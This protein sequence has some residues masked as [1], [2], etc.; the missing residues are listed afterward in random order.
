MIP[1][2]H[3]IDPFRYAPVVAETILKRRQ[4]ASICLETEDPGLKA[5]VNQR[6]YAFLKTFNLEELHGVTLITCA[7]GI[8]GVPIEEKDQLKLDPN[9]NLRL[10]EADGFPAIR[11]ASILFK[12]PNRLLV[13]T[14]A[15][16]VRP[17]QTYSGW[18]QAIHGVISSINPEIA[19]PESI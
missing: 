11:K 14:N 5:F 3:E 16:P 2:S 8:M 17:P 1:A 7:L 10:L 6:A 12:E 13:K 4:F 19:W 18:I 9:A 15:T